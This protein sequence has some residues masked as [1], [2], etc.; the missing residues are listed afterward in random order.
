[1]ESKIELNEQNT[2]NIIVTGCIHGSMDKMYKEIQDYEKEKKK[3][4][5]LVL[6]TGDLNV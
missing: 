4:I 6:C 3:K 2:L 5:D 1:M